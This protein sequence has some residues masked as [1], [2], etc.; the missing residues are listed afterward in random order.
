MVAFIAEVFEVGSGLT[1]VQDGK[2]GCPSCVQWNSSLSCL[3]MGNQDSVTLFRY[4]ALLVCK[5]R[6][7]PVCFKLF[8]LAGAMQE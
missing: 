6:A 1:E 2:K 8:R 5:M 4:F 3:F 7:I